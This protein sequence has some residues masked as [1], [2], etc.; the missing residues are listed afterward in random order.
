MAPKGKKG[1]SMLPAFYAADTGDDVSLAALLT[2]DSLK[3]V[4]AQRNKDGWSVLHQAAFSGHISIVQMLLAA[5]A[6]V[7][8]VMQKYCSC[9]SICY[10]M[11]ETI[12]HACHLYGFMTAVQISGKCR[13]GDTPLH[14]ASA[15]GAID[16]AQALVD[17][18]AKLRVKD[19]DGEEPLVSETCIT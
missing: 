13:D 14:Y 2:G 5:G 12:M 7:C 18:G 9:K 10:A 16:C 17:A 4:M 19:N 11:C 8:D 6:E 1:P 15:Q 3:T